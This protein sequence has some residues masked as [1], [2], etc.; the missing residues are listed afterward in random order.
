MAGTNKNAVARWVR[1]PTQ[2]LDLQYGAGQL[3]DE[4]AYQILSAGPQTPS[5]SSTVS[6]TGW[7]CQ[8]FATSASPA[9]NYFF[10]VP[11][12]TSYDFST[13]LTW[14]R[15]IAATA[16]NQI[17]ETSATFTP[18]MGTLDLQLLQSNNRLSTSGA[19]FDQSISS[20]DNVQDIFQRTLA[21][22][23]Y[24][25]RVSL[26]TNS[27]SASYALASNCSPWHR[28]YLFGLALAA[29]P[30]TGPCGARWGGGTPTATGFC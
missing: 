2:P 5:L 7:S 12:G 24:D 13:I 17:L 26:A 14:E 29:P 19:L 20:I 1:T 28:E 11:A 25:L 22:G 27:G 8:T 9:T 18:S 3:N 10:V 16:G 30:T 6:S 21:P 4:N 23:T 15:Q